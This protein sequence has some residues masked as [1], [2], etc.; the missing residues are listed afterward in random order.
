MIMALHKKL[1]KITLLCAMSF[2]DLMVVGETT[3][4]ILNL[5]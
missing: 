2:I 3:Q 5:P 4:E 1:M